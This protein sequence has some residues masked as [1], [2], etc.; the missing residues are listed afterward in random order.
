MV[1]EPQESVQL[2]AL[3]TILTDG[4]R[5]AN[6]LD[7]EKRVAEFED[8]LCRD[9]ESFSPLPRERAVLRGEELA[10]SAEIGPLWP[11]LAHWQKRP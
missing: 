10:K 2:N 8:R 6:Y 7:L 9:P 1:E 4:M 11:I 5:T 3:K